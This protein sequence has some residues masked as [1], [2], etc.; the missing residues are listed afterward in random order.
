MNLVQY[1]KNP[2]KLIVRISE[3]T[4]LLSLLPDKQYIKLI[5]RLHFNR[6][7]DLFNPQTFNE[8]LQWLKLYDRKPEY[9]IMVDKYEVKNLVASRLGE[10]YIIPTLGIYDS[11]DKIDF[12]NLPDKF[13]LKCT[14]DSGGLVI[15]NDKKKFNKKSAKKKINKSLR[16]NF[17]KYA[18][19]WP[20][21]NVQPRIIIEK[22]MIDNKLGELRD[23]KFFCFN[24]KV[25]VFKIDFDR[26]SN[27]R[28]N[29]FDT[30]GNLIDLG[31]KICPPDFSKKLELPINLKKMKE[32]AEIMSKGIPFLRVDFYEINGKIYFGEL[33]FFPAA[34]LG[35]FT[36]DKWDR[37]L[38]KWLSL[39]NLLKK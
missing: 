25:K 33:T 15:V 2:S 27:H 39:E 5:Y 31:E 11:F 21:K 9:T 32:L 28:A 13:V 23:Y 4:K 16:R 6:K 20:Y 36:D 24:G 26:H 34:G 12:D 35:K 22:Y 38:G 8:K 14:H 17:Y 18:R 19:E 3:D 10:E 7:L 30:N 1:L 29:Y 37:M